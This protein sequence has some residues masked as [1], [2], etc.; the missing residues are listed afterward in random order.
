MWTVNPPCFERDRSTQHIF[1]PLPILNNGDPDRVG[2]DLA[3]SAP[4]D[5]RTRNV[6]GEPAFEAR[7]GEDPLVVHPVV[8][9]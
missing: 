5:R 2:L 1:D 8:A 3:Q 4:R 7:N 6:F 9:L